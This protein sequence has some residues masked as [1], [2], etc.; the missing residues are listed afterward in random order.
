MQPVAIWSRVPAANRIRELLNEQL[1]VKQLRE[2]EKQINEA[3]A[4]RLPLQL[5]SRS[6]EAA[7]DEHDEPFYG[8][9][10]ELRAYACR[11]SRKRE[12]AASS[13]SSVSMS[14]IGRCV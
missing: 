7:I 3:L 11:A 6:V 13:A 4:S 5:R 8:K 1:S 2:Y 14:S 12:R 10:P 9:T